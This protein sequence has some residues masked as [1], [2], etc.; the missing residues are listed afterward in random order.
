MSD[1]ISDKELK[2]LARAVL[3][4]GEKDEPLDAAAKIIGFDNYESYCLNAD[5]TDFIHSVQNALCTG[6]V[7]MAVSGRCEMSI[8]IGDCDNESVYL[9]ARNAKGMLSYLKQAAGAFGEL[10]RAL[11]M[12]VAKG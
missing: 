4:S 11:E 1:T 5:Q 10:S 2:E 6:A 9:S 3:R 7:Q 8:T 12:E